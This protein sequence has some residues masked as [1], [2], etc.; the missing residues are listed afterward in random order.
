MASCRSRCLLFSYVETLSTELNRANPAGSVELARI[1]G[2][3][4]ASK[5]QLVQAGYTEIAFETF[6]DMFLDLLQSLPKASSEEWH[7]CFLNDES[8]DYYTWF[9]R[10][11]TACMRHKRC[12][13]NRA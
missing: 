3:V 7:S 4:K 1:I 2:V 12:P 9:M 8:A 5:E 10:L 6:Y 13:P 11:L